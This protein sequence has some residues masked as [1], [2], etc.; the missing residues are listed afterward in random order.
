M[1]EQFKDVEMPI[2]P[3]HEVN[4]HPEVPEIFHGLVGLDHYIVRDELFE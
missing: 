3:A 4:I 2:K 1:Y